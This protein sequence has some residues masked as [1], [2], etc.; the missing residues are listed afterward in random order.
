[1]NADPIRV[2][3]KIYPR[4]ILNWEMEKRGL[5]WTAEIR[6]LLVEVDME[7][8]FHN[9]QDVNLECIRNILCLK[10]KENWKK[11]YCEVPKLRSYVL[12]KSEMCLEPYVYKVI[13]RSHRSILAQLRCGILPLKIETGRFTNVPVEFCLCLFCSD[14]CVE[15]EEHFLSHCE[16]YQKIRQSLFVKLS[17]E[18]ALPNTLA[19]GVKF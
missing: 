5:N 17:K 14:N 1:M 15:D 8:C 13:N 18:L 16:L 6:N 2:P 7:G 3:G 19:I 9:L 11:D 10:D 12:F 4:K